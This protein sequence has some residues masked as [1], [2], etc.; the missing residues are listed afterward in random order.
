V[1]Q[2]L[3][4]TAGHGPRTV[5]L[6]AR[7]GCR[8]PEH[9]AVAPTLSYYNIHEESTLHL[10]LRLRGGMQSNAKMATKK[11]KDAEEKRI[12]LSVWVHPSLHLPFELHPSLDATN[13]TKLTRSFEVESSKLIDDLLWDVEDVLNKEARRARCQR[14]GLYLDIRLNVIWN[15]KDHGAALDPNS[16]VGDHFESGDTFGV[17]GE[18]VESEVGGYKA[19]AAGAFCTV[20][21]R[22]DG[23]AAACGMDLGG[24]RHVVIP[25]LVEGFSYTQVAV[26][27]HAVLLQS[28]GT[29]RCSTDRRD[30]PSLADG[31][32]YEQVSAG[33]HHTVFLR[34]DGTAT[35]CGRTPSA[36]ATSR[37]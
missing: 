30:I 5:A 15:V 17:H 3:P 2:G 14:G 18:I 1:V 7:A 13:S 9:L 22:D 10:V 8:P 4:C 31:V 37:R 20:L 28:D 24:E 33:S 26:H 35:A 27:D 16:T 34:S 6:A 32:R 36:S 25:E 29:V 21:L 12:A 19:V 11:A 23:R